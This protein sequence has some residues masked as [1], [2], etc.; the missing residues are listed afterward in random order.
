MTAPAAVILQEVPR[1]KP[2]QCNLAVERLRLR[3]VRA[4]R[5]LELER[6]RRIVI[7]IK[8][9]QLIDQV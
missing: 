8:K 6:W 4:T 9:F 2:T 3:E 7:E 1:T 5:Q